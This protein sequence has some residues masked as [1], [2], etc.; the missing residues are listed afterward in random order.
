MH[1]GDNIRVYDYENLDEKDPWTG[2]LSAAMFALRATYRTTLQATPMQLVSG[3]D[4]ILNTKFE[5]DWK[6]IKERKQRLVNENNRREN[7]TRRK[8]E[9]KENDSVLFRVPVQ[10]KYGENEY[11]GPYTIKTVRNNRTVVLQMGATI[12]TVNIRNIKPYNE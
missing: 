5:A 4:A 3:R 1:F 7:M 6:L 12:E 11:K 2:P 10:G 9:Y 8:H